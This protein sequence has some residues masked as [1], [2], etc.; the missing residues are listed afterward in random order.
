M[1]HVRMRTMNTPADKFDE[2]CMV[3]LPLFGC[4]RRPSWSLA[5]PV[6][7]SLK[8]CP[9]VV[10]ASGVRSAPA[11]ADFTKVNGRNDTVK[12]DGEGV[13]LGGIRQRKSLAK[14]GEGTPAN[15]CTS[16]RSLYNSGMSRDR[17]LALNLSYV[18]VAYNVCEGL[19]S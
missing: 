16:K 12:L 13:S 14:Q 18:T 9:V 5:G 19:V 3:S 11:P 10:L 4:R 15:S 8:E 7:Y 6:G 2:R 17:A 1:P